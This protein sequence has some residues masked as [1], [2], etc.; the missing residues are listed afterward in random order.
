VLFELTQDRCDLID[1]ISEGQEIEITFSLKGRKWQNPQGETKYFT[2][3]QAFKI[4]AKGSAPTGT[5][6]AVIPVPTPDDDLPF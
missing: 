6:P 2:N 5:T 4:L 1:P 3:L